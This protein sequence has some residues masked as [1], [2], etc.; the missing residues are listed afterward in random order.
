ME[1]IKDQRLQNKMVTADA[2]G[3]PFGEIADAIGVPFG[4]I[5]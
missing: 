2:I 3:V 5:Q 4:E 1:G